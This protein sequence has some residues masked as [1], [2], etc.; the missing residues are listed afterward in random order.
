M[1]NRERDRLIEQHLPLVQAIA[2]K[3]KQNIRARVENDDLVAYGHKGL[4]EAADRFDAHQGVA[5]STFAYYRIR[6][7]MFD[8]LRAMGWYSRADYARYRAEERANEYLRNQAEREGAARAAGGTTKDAEKPASETVQDIADLLGSITTIHIVSLEAAGHVADETFDSP[9]T[10]ID[11]LKL[12]PRVAEGL[13]RLPEKERR[14]VEL[15]YFEN[16]TLEEAGAVLGL[17]KSW[18]CRLH[19]R[20][21][22]LLKETLADVL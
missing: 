4:V 18:G 10:L 14:L 7:A 22:L 8:G 2:R 15:Y 9:D 12:R 13:R 16:K 5:F 21:I 11:L 17:S 6:G 19:A 3:V 20:A 1:V